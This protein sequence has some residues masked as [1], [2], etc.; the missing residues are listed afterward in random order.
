[1]EEIINIK[2]WYN[3]LDTS[4]KIG[5]SSVITG[6]ITYKITSKNHTYEIEKM[7]KNREIEISKEKL[8]KKFIYFEESIKDTEPFLDALGCLTQEWNKYEFKKIFLKE[9]SLDEQGKYTQIDEKYIN[10]K[11]NSSK[12]ARNLRILG[13]DDILKTL[14]TIDGM[15]NLK[16]AE[17]RLNE[18]T[19]IQQPELKEL[20][21]KV[22]TL[23]KDYDKQV[24][25][26]FEK[27][28]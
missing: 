23:I 1:M 8:N 28:S 13:L 18:N 3:L 10:S 12:V 7:K 24:K 2:D 26:A 15:I 25:E 16:R 11:N 14:Q 20:Y 19:F 4:I 9:L 27:L 5:L 6:V 22:N 17:I 21:K